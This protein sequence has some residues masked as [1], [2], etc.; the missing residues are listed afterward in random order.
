RAAPPPRP[1]PSSTS[2]LPALSRTRILGSPSSLRTTA[3]P[4]IRVSSLYCLPLACPPASPNRYSHDDPPDLHWAP[5]GTAVAT[6][7]V[8]PSHSA[9]MLTRSPS[10]GKS[11][12]QPPSVLQSRSTAAPLA[13]VPL[14]FSVTT[15]NLPFLVP[16]RI[17]PQPVSSS[18]SRMAAIDCTC[19]S[20]M[21]SVSR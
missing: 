5:S 3:K 9:G 2:V 13:A 6:S 15:L 17:S 12:R 11:A 7:K 1:E 10:V 14:L 20:L 4:T 16:L 21:S 18:G 8:V 19:V